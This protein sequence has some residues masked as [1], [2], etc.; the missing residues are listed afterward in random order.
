M[1]VC[2]CVCVCVCLCVC[3]SVIYKHSFCS[4]EP[5]AKNGHKLQLCTD[6]NTSFY[7]KIHE[8]AKQNSLWF[9]DSYCTRIQHPFQ[10]NAKPYNNVVL[11][12]RNSQQSQGI[13]HLLATKWNQA[14]LPLNLFHIRMECPCS[15]RENKPHLTWLS[16]VKPSISTWASLDETLLRILP[17]N[18]TLTRF[19][20]Q[21]NQ[22][23]QMKKKIMTLPDPFQT[24][25]NHISAEVK[26]AGAYAQIWGNALTHTKVER[27]FHQAIRPDTYK[28][29]VSTRG[30]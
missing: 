20:Y 10:W 6:F 30:V 3:V 17:V 29:R 13:F 25:L 16:D 12:Q 7:A 18:C 22:A 4:N 23:Q 2:A 15:I 24:E 8:K 5:R 1:C 26:H 11:H 28:I 21:H 27:Y 19:D 14:S 9:N